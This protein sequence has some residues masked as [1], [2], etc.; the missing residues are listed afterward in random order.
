[1]NFLL[2]TVLRILL[3]LILLILNL[4]VLI[5]SGKRVSKVMVLGLTVILLYCMFFQGALRKPRINMEALETAAEKVTARELNEG[6]YLT[7]QGSCLVSVYKA[8]PYEIEKYG[9]TVFP[10]SMFEEKGSLSNGFKYYISS[11][12]SCRQA[13]GLY[14]HNWYEGTVLIATDE[15]TIIELNY[16]VDRKIDDML[17]FLCA[18]PV[19]KELDFLSWL[20][21]GK[22]MSENG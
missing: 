20:Q 11:L 18:P 14:M 21:P 9:N 3:L 8:D 5:K 6:F 22:Y 10:E 17:G 2:G 4:I 16:S 12:V 19:I 13:E 7:E 15:T 1:M